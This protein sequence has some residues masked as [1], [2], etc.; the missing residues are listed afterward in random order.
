MSL[1]RAARDYLEYNNTEKK[2]P[3]H[4]GSLGDRKA[5]YNTGSCFDWFSLAEA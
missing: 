3:T 4:V 5:L 1:T 2:N